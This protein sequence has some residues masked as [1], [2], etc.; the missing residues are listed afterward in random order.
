MQIVK[1]KLEIQTQSVHKLFKNSRIY[2]IINLIKL[3]V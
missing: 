3:K 1:E 2:D